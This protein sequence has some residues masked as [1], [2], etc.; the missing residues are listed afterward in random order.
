VSVPVYSHTTYD[1]VSDE[2]TTISAADIVIVEGINVLQVPP[3]RAGDDQ[4]HVSDFFDFSIYVDAEEVD[5]EQWYI[6]RTFALRDGAFQQPESFFHF[7]TPL[8][9][10]DVRA[11]ARS[12]WDTINGRNLRENIAPTRSRAHLVLQKGRDHSVERILLRK[13]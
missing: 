4:L 6:E 11:F 9:D 12:I 2:T 8:S 3:T 5:I 1:V 13:L 10:D 7:L